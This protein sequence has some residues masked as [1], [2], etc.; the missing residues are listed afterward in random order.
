METAI[1]ARSPHAI[2][3][4]VLGAAVFGAFAGLKTGAVPP[5][6]AKVVVGVTVPIL[7][8]TLLSAI[9]AASRADEAAPRS[10]WRP[11]AQASAEH[12]LEPQ[13]WTGVYEW[14]NARLVAAGVAEDTAAILAAH[15]MFSV[16]ELERLLDAGCP[17]G[18]ALRI[19]W[20]A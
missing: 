7:F 17:L 13:S 11:A 2:V 6:L 16:H 10:G 19:L 12:E 5:L 8:A 14:R 3:A 20:P 15:R 9:P 4:I 1:R 18:T